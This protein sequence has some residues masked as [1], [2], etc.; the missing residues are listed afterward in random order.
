MTSDSDAAGDRISPTIVPRWEWRTFAELDAAEARLAALTPERVQDSAEV[1]LL[2]TFS[3]TSVKLR[4]EL[5]D[6]KRLQRVNADGLELWMPVMKTAFPL[7]DDE[8]ETVLDALAVSGS[9]LDR[10]FY[11][12]EDFANE[13]VRHDSHLLALPVRKRRAHYTVDECM[14]ELTDIETSSGAVR[15]IAIE[16]PDPALV[17]STIDRLGLG[18]LANV[19]MARGLKTLAGFGTRRSAVIDVGTNS[20]KFHLGEREADG[21][22]RTIADRAEVT[23]LGEGLER[24]GAL[25]DQA[26]QRTIASIAALR[27]EARRD[28]ADAIAIVATA[29][30]RSATNAGAFEHALRDRCGIDIEIISGEEEG[31]LAYL[32]ATSALLLPRARLVVFDSGGG[33]TQFT[34]G[35]PEHVEERF[36]LDVGA[37]RIAER[38]G[39]DGAVSKDVLANAIDSIT[40]ALQQLAARPR[41]DAVIGIGGTVTNLAA[42]KHQLASYDAD[43][44][45]G[46][47]LDVSEI[48]RQIE[49]YRTRPA[50][51]RRNI[52]GL[53][54]GRAEV[55]LSGASIVRTILTMLGKESVTVSDRGLRHGVFIE[56]FAR[57]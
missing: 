53:Q 31:R 25:T 14:V 6:V 23:R 15:T 46:T 27:E 21:T 32:A 28:G 16:S 24:S 20:V 47:V 42:V 45:H 18:G 57:A 34:F 10:A 43:V 37:V 48:D 4:D 30:L 52:V 9:P 17:R 1:Y 50:A 19:N 26:M 39:L 51:V 7:S 49:M 54:P 5:V 35:E 3:D 2:S 44:V 13:L 55:I 40:D 36:S 12:R 33:S 56:R 22:V 29:G 8:A 41:P 38:Y 11:T